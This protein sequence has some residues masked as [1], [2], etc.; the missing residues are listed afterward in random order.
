MS[1]YVVTTGATIAIHSDR[2][3]S[4]SRINVVTGEVGSGGTVMP[5]SSSSTVRLYFIFLPY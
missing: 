1:F 5:T 3:V 4:S 2:R